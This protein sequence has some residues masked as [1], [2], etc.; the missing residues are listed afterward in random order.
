MIGIDVPETQLSDYSRTSLTNYDM[1]TSRCGSAI[2]RNVSCSSVLFCLSVH[3]PIVW[4]DGS[5]YPTFNCWK[6]IDMIQ[7]N[8]WSTECVANS[9]AYVNR[10]RL[11]TKPGDHGWL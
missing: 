8:H 5:D 3:K 2:T 6:M 11:V 4:F 9:L 1:Q 7:D 10:K